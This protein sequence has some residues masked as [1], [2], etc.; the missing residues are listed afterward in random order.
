MIAV[1]GDGSIAVGAGASVILVLVPAGAGMI[2]GKRHFSNQE[3]HV[4]VVLCAAHYEEIKS[5]DHTRISVAWDSIMQCVIGLVSL[6]F[7]PLLFDVSDR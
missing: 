4:L 1:V 5:L 3:N 6:I 2:Q 7:T